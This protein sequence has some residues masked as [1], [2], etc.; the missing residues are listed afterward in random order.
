M[1][2]QRLDRDSS[3]KV[4]DSVK[5][6]ENA[7]LFSHTTSEVERGRLPFYKDYDLYKVT[8]FASLP[9]FSF[10]YLSDGTFFHYLD[11]TDDPIQIVND[12]GA[13]DLNKS[14]VMAYLQFYFAHV[15]AD[16]GDIIVID[17]PHDMPLLDSLDPQAYDAVFDN[18]KP[19]EIHHENGTYQIE[20]DLY[21]DSQLVRATVEVGHKGR[22]KIKHQKATMH[23][24][25]D[26]NYFDGLLQK[27]IGEYLGTMNTDTT[28]NGENGLQSAFGDRGT[29]VNSMSYGHPHAEEIIEGAEKIIRESD[30]GRLLL[31]SKAMGNIPVSIMKGSGEAGFS[32]DAKIIYIQIPGKVRIADSKIIIQYVKAL[33]EADQ[34]LIGKVAPDPNKDIMKYAIAMHA[35]NMDAITYVCKFVK[36]LTNSSYFSVLIDTID[37]L[38]YKEVYEIYAKGGTTEEIFKAYSGR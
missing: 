13:L 30:T 26:S 7:G 9:S 38:G 28:N 18:H 17:N 33:R 31:K 20:T 6:A 12:K 29:N 8:N 25:M 2:W 16:D 24:V 1:H 4:I 10:E 19:A 3:I 15:G 27:N 21:T 5:S 32:P 37:E 23:E 35:K 22:I 14:N 36:E 11:G 34:H